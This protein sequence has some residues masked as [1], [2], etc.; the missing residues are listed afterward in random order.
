MSYS[1][2]KSHD[3]WATEPDF[4]AELEAELEALDKMQDEELKE[5]FAIISTEELAELEALDLEDSE[6]L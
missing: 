3:K 4:Y 1:F 5:V 2:D 6:V